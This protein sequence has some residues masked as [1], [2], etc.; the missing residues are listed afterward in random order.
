MLHNTLGEMKDPGYAPIGSRG[1]IFF[2][3]F[4]HPLRLTVPRLD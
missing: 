1:V 2:F 3:F 4:F